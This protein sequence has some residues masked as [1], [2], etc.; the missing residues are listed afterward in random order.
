MISERNK[1]EEVLNYGEMI[2]SQRGDL[3]NVPFNEILDMFDD[4]TQEMIHNRWGVLAQVII[5]SVTSW[6][7]KALVEYLGKID[8]P[9]LAYEYVGYAL[10][11]NHGVVLEELLIEA[12]GC[13]YFD[14]ITKYV[15]SNLQHKRKLH[16]HLVNPFLMMLEKYKDHSVYHA[17]LHYYAKGI[18]A[19]DGCLAVVTEIGSVS[20]EVQYQLIYNLR[21]YW[22][23]DKSEEA[24]EQIGLFLSQNTIWAWKAAMDY[25]EWRIPNDNTILEKYY[26]KI[27]ELVDRHTEL[28]L[29]VISLLVEYIL[30][31]FQDK[32]KHTQYPII[33]SKL[34]LL[35]KQVP[36]AK[37]RFLQKIEY[38][39]DYPLDIYDIFQDILSVPL[40]DGSDTLK[41]LDNCFSFILE[42]Q[43]YQAVLENMFKC[44]SVNK[45]RSQ[46]TVF[47]NAL[48]STIYALSEYAIQIT[49][50]ALTYV[51]TSDLDKLFFGLGLLVKLGNIKELYNKKMEEDPSYA[52]SYDEDKLIRVMKAVLFFTVDE[53]QISHIAFSLLYLAKGTTQ[54]Y[55]QFCMETV[56]YD[57]PIKMHEIS[58]SYAQNC[59]PVQEEFVVLVKKAYASKVELQEKARDIPDLYPSDEH[60]RI[61]RRAQRVQSGEIS[62]KANEM[63]FFSSLFDRRVLKYG[64]RSGYVIKGIKNQQFYQSSPY[65]ELRYEHHLPM[66]YVIDPVEYSMRRYAFLQEV[67]ERASDN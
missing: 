16:L 65:Q 3:K 55:L 15:S 40:T 27:D 46:F 58:E 6:E 45:Y 60:E 25:C 18:A 20:G 31:T 22:F 57:Y 56:F 34:K 32:E 39:N 29:H 17:T 21:R 37:D 36:S 47:F 14:T 24:A 52:G 48:D 12:A 49:D 19:C 11:S 38:I 1:I 9:P 5:S 59:L 26:P 10:Q 8:C 42:K 43:G 54:K 33:S 41:H 67:E 61:Y 51:M 7:I 2:L 4:G 30:Q 53:D 62:K 28:K 44:F 66:T 13:K 23:I 35:L 64:R 50:L 63:S